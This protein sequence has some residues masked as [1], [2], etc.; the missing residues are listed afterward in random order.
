MN[1]AIGTGREAIVTVMPE[2][3]GAYR[4]RIDGDDSGHARL[5]GGGQHVRLIWNRVERQTVAHRAGPM[6]WINAP[7]G[8]LTVTDVTYPRPAEEADEADGTVRAPMNGTLSALDVAVGD[9][10]SA[11]QRL[12]AMEAMKMDLPLKAAIDGRIAALHASVGDQVAA[13]SAIIEITPDS[14]QSTGGD[15]N[16]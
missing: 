15:E 10:V 14:E 2:D 9:A 1:L 12:G 7:R 11:G 8:V 4:V 16:G 13:R 3:G 6:V 5:E